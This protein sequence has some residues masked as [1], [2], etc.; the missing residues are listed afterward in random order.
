MQ[1]FDYIGIIRA[2]PGA[3][4]KCSEPLLERLNLYRPT[5]AKDGKMMEK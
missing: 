4:P 5:G 1:V 3:A 2:A